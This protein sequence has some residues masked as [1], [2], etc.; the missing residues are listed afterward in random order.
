MTGLLDGQAVVVTGAGR[1]LGRAYALGLAA[2][3]AR[4]VVNDRDGDPAESVAAEIR[5]AGGEAVVVADAVG[6]R[7][8]AVRLV[9]RSRDAFG[10]VD[11]MVT[12]AGADRRGPVLDL[13]DDDWELTLTT[14]LMGS[15]FCSVEAARAMRDQGGGGAIVNVTSDAFHQGVPT[16]A[17]Y[18][19]SK[20]GIYGLTR[21]LAAELAPFDIAV[22]AIAPPATRT[23]PMLAYTDSLA[24]MGL[25]AQQVAAFKAYLQEPEDIAPLV[26]FLASPAGRRLTGRVLGVTRRELVSLEPPAT[27]RLGSNDP[28]PWTF[29]ELAAAAAGLA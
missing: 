15:L 11:V 4:L 6:T 7:A 24:T 25:D 9:E 14:H 2:A 10:R 28:G 23:E 17:P 8:A 16:L 19:V 1:G 13:T 29:D 3:G 26:V 18:C 21:V 12:N 27:S 5:E 22:N 20:G